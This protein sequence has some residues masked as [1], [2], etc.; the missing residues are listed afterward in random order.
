MHAMAWRDLDPA[1]AHGELQHDPTLRL[2]DVRTPR[3]YQ[4]H[5]LPGALLIP[6]Q[7]LAQR[8]GE[9]DAQANWLVYCEHGRRSL[10]ACALLAQQSFGKLANLRGG[11]AHWLGC[12]LPVE[13]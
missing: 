13:R 8:C 1:D 4:S 9:L 3:E 2:L 7:E 5:H 6:V 10:V 11:M 12:G